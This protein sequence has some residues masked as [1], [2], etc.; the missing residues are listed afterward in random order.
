[1]GNLIDLTGKKFNR[2]VVIER[3]GRDKRGKQA[4]WLCRCDC[5]NE[6]VIYG[7][8]LRTGITQSCGC[9]RNEKSSA[10]DKL[11]VGENS[12]AWKGGR[13]L[14]GQGYVLVFA[15]SHP[16]AAKSGHVLEHILVAERALGEYLPQGSVIHHINGIR[17]DNRLENLWWFPSHSEHAAL[18]NSQRKKS[19][20]GRCAIAETTAIKNNQ[21]KGMV[22]PQ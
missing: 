22:I 19:S 16:R 11:R 3:A 1:M 2:L 15:K 20:V 7:Q 17:D 6:M 9:L 21:S 12:L 13:F 4:M 14:N 8:H 10:R 18:H 5:G